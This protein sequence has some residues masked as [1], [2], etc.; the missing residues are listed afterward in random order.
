MSLINNTLIARTV[1]NPMLM[2]LVVD[3]IVY[4]F[5]NTINSDFKP[6]D[7]EKGDILRLLQYCEEYDKLIE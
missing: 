1:D 2:K 5:K 7:I 6:N 3:S 4:K